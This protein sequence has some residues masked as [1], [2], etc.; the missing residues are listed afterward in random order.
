MSF[1]RDKKNISVLVSLIIF[2]LI[3]IS[4]QVYLE[5]AENFFE[6]ATFFVFAS[7]K[8][9][10]SAVT[11]G[12]SHF[13][14]NY[15]ALRNAQKKNRELNR[16]LARLR[17]ENL[18]LKN[19]LKE[20]H[21]YETIKKRLIRF[22]ENI[23]LARVIGLDFSNLYKSAV[24]DKGYA[25][26]VEKDMIILDKY[27]HLLGRIVEPISLKE[28]RVQLIT[29]NLSGVGIYT[30]KSRIFGILKGTGEK[31]CILGHVLSTERAISPGESVWTSGHDGIYPQGIQVGRI[32][33]VDKTSSLF[34]KVEVEPD[35][36]LNSL[37]LVAVIFNQNGEVK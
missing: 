32:F 37:D 20:Y 8:H 25:D 28:A 10:F 7:V 3:L 15:F 27:G 19:S 30:D 24:I 26:G 1:I 23:L 31:M 14:E 18:Y 13:W 9:G 6:K 2:N 29:D 21:E 16:E 34:Q 17:Q 33:S 36:D 4:L 5:E 22:H 35:Y 11:T 12:I